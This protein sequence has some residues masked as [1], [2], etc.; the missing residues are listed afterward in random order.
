MKGAAK[1][2]LGQPWESWTHARL[3]TGAPARGGAT[4]ALGVAWILLHAHS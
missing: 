3:D 2:E 4:A 1:V